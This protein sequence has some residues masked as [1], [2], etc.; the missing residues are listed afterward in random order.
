M[1]AES[2]RHYCY[3]EG[4]EQKPQVH[5]LTVTSPFCLVAVYIWEGNFSVFFLSRL[6]NSFGGEPTQICVLPSFCQFDTNQSHF[7][8]R[9]VNWENAPHQTGQWASLWWLFLIEG[10]WGRAQSAVGS[11]TPGL[12]V[13]GAIRRQT[14]QITMNKPVSSVS[15]RPL[16]Q[17]L[18][19]LPGWWARS[20]RIKWIV[21]SPV[22]FWLVFEHR[23]RKLSSLSIPG[24]LE[25]SQC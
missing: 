5:T 19:R 13:P 25:L 11:V 12:V 22:W 17:F 3:C 21:C 9:N 16:L 18:P 8:R 14:E 23:H 15:L 1:W 6:H 7:G 20:I 10:W 2:D 4:Y 24:F